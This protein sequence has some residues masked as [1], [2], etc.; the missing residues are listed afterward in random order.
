MEF[1]K[2]RPVGKAVSTLMVQIYNRVGV[3]NTSGKV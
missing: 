1:N 3:R 2:M